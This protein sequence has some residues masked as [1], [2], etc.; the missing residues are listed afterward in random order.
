MLGNEG[1]NSSPTISEV[2]LYRQ[3]KLQETSEEGDEKEGDSVKT[4][5]DAN[6]EVEVCPRTT[7]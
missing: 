4:L 5:E 7:D 2:E 1:K 6:N 3:K